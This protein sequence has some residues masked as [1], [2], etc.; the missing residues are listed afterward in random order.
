MYVEFESLFG[1]IVRINTDKVN[2]ISAKA[3]NATTTDIICPGTTFTVN[4]TIDEVVMKLVKSL[5]R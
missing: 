3:T 2:G 1:G 5:K 4:E